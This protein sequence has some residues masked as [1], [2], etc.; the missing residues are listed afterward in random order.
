MLE[1]EG[2]ALLSGQNVVLARMGDRNHLMNTQPGGAERIIPWHTL[3]QDFPKLYTVQIH[4]G[5]LFPGP[6]VQR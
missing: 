5:A 4:G 1:N 3:L 2:I 6:L